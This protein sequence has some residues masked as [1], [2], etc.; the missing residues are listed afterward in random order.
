[1][2]KR[3]NRDQEKTIYLMDN[4]TPDILIIGAGLT[5]LTLAYFL[6]KRNISVKII[7]AR[8]RVGG[9]IYTKEQTNTTSQEMGATWLNKQHT[10]LWTLLNELNLR[11]FEQLMDKDAIYEPS[12]M[13]P[14]QLVELPPNNDP[15][16]R[17]V[18]GSSQLIQA[19]RDRLDPESFHLGEF[20]Q[21]IEGVEGGVRVSTNKQTWTVSKVI[22]TLPPYLF[23]KKIAV[24]PILPSSLTGIME[25]T[26][27]WMGESIKVSLTYEKPFW[28]D[29]GKSGTIFS[30]VGPVPE[31]YDHSNAEDTKFA[32]KGFLNGSYFSVSKEERLERILAQLTKYFGTVVQ[33]FLTYEEVVW[34]KEPFTFAPYTSPMIPHRNNGHSVYQVPYLDGKLW[35]AGS[36]TARRAPGYMEGAVQSA[37][38]INTQL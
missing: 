9:R 5:G 14:P 16:F 25:E 21:G 7:E 28:R 6:Q 8:E 24:Q 10:S 19:L 36:E 12:S 17:I 13:S 2:L 33:N 15:S 30:N 35:I 3:L 38:F 23:Y 4:K 11:T 32:L 1:M 31:M 34:Q 27:T 22:S 18:G 37:A 26:H 29:A 20:V